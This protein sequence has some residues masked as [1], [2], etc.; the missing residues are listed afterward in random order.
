MGADTYREVYRRQHRIIAH[1]LALQT[2][3]HDKDCIVVEHRDFANL[4][5][6][7]RLRS[8]RKEWLT[9]DFRPWFT[10]QEFTR[11]ANSE[12]LI[13][14]RQPIGD[15][16]YYSWRSS[17]E[18][19]K[20]MEAD[21]LRCGTCSDLATG[22][23]FVKEAELVSELVSLATGLIEPIKRTTSTETQNA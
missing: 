12:S 16:A 22:K 21:G 4:F 14:S 3:L 20:R 10:Y 23:T 1:Y 11:I 19:I 5:D 6:I 17:T 8:P 7:F 2:W 13:L 18:I 15:P 9:E